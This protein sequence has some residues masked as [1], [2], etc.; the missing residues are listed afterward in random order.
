MIELNDLDTESVQYAISEVNRSES[1]LTIRI[2]GNG[3]GD[4]TATRQFIDALESASRSICLEFEGY[5]ISSAAILFY[6][7]KLN[8]HTSIR[9]SL[10]KGRCVFVFHRP[11]F[12]CN[13]YVMFEE[14]LIGS[15]KAALK[16]QTE[17]CD[18]LFDRIFP[19]V[20]RYTHEDPKTGV[21]L[22]ETSMARKAYYAGYD[23]VQTVFDA[24][25]T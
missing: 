22:H 3:G 21:W 23:V 4:I 2:H 1:S 14:N 25:I 24:N 12:I 10:P 7:F 16:E 17:Y 5:A 15:R 6:W 13:S 9:L 8:P 20:C 18:A 11:R 19:D